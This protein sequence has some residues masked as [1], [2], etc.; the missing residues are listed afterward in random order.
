[1]RCVIKSD[2]RF[3]VDRQRRFVLIGRGRFDEDLDGDRRILG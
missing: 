1:M 2:E 3:G